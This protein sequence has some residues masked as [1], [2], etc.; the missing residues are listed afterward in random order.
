MYKANDKWVTSTLHLGPIFGRNTMGACVDQ[1]AGSYGSELTKEKLMSGL[2]L[3]EIEGWD[4]TLIVIGRPESYEEY[5]IVELLDP[6]Y[7]LKGDS[8]GS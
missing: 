5:G 2:Y 4:D 7:I 8:D 1:I 6:E 3:F